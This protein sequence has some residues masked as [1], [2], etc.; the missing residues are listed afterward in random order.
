MF[1]TRNTSPLPSFTQ[2]VKH[3]TKVIF[4]KFTMTQDVVS[5]CSVFEIKL[6]KAKHK[7]YQFFTVLESTIK[8]VWRHAM[9]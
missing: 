8:Q 2:N 3:F 4:D 1:G 6:K 9:A 5:L 7:F